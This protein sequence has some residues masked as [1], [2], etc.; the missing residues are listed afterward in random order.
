MTPTPMPPIGFGTA[1]LKD[2][3][4]RGL[5]AMALEVGFRHVDTAQ[6]YENERDVGQ[7]VRDSGLDRGAIFVT[8]KIHQDRF[9]DGTALESARASIDRLGGPADLILVHWPPR[10]VP[11]ARVIETL[12]QV[13]DAG[14]TRLIGVSNFNRP[15]LRE[16]ADLAPIATNQVEFHCLIDQ[17]A[18]LADA[19]ARNIPLTA[20]M[21]ILRGKVL[22]E[23]AV[24]AIA[25]AHDVPPV[26]V[27]LAWIIGHGVIPLVLSS[28]RDRLAEA[29]AA[30]RLM[31]TAE[32]M[33]TLDALAR[34][35]NHR[36]SRHGDWEPDWD[37]P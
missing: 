6:M 25:A 4:W 35:R 22:A 33:A 19:N 9:R 2:T 34:R 30:T 3:D 31:L 21:P 7:G 37:A 16:A 8:T 15:Q 12:L 18:L 13:Q 14:L 24:T 1:P 36:A 29:F 26:Q 28:R 20:Y 17:F 10:G 27:A 11:V 32:D 23:P 5:T